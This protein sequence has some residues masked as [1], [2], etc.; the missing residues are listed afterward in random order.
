MMMTYYTDIEANDLV[1]G[2]E[3]EYRVTPRIPATRLDPPEGGEIEIDS[4][5]VMTVED[6]GGCKERRDIGQRAVALDQLAWDTV[7]EDFICDNYS[8]MIERWNDV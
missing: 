3:V 5:Y 1:L 7:D 4:V 6:H 2:I 8:E